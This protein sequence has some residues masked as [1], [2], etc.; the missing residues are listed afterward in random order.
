MEHPMDRARRYV[1]STFKDVEGRE[2]VSAIIPNSYDEEVEQI[3]HLVY[4]RGSPPRAY[5]LGHRHEWAIV[6]DMHMRVKKR[7]EL[8]DYA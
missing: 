7:F 5:I 6:L 4:L 8:G 2:W 3:T 1:R